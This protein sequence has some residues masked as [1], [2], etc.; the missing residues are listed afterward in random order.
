VE[1][2][3][4]INDY[5]YSEYVDDAFFLEGLC[6]FKQSERVEKDQTKTFEAKARIER[7]LR[8]FPNSVRQQEARN[9][10]KEIDT[11]LAE[12]KFMS[13]WLYYSM[14]H[15]NAALI[16]FN[17]TIDLYEGTIAAA[18]SHYF[19]GRIFEKRKDIKKAISE[20]EKVILSGVDIEEK[21]DAKKHLELLKKGTDEG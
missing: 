1:Y 19:K 7:F 3:V 18:R 13:A 20:Y 2:R 15:Y 16:Y 6:F 17:K 21:N 4:L 8:L 5:G 12:K 10:L 9:L 14:G 11:K